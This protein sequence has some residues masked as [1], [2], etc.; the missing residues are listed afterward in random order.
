MG[1]E[2]KIE[3]RDRNTVHVSAPSYLAMGLSVLKY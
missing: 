2:H 1:E 3:I